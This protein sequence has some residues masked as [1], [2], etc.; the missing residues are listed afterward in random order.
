MSAT[1]EF[2]CLR[3]MGVQAQVTRCSRNVKEIRALLRLRLQSM[4]TGE[5]LILELCPETPPT[6]WFNQ[7]KNNGGGKTMV[8]RQIRQQLVVVRID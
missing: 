3:T 4:S 8:V 2:K 1:I 5:W 6:Y 7:S